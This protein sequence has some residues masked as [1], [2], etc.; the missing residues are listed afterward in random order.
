MCIRDRIYGQADNDSLQGWSGNDTVVGGSGADKIW[1]GDGRDYLVGSDLSGNTTQSTYVVDLGD[2][3]DG[4]A[5]NDTIF[6]GDGN[7][8][9]IGG[10]GDDWLGRISGS[11]MNLSD[12]YYTSFSNAE[13]GDDTMDGG[14]GNDNLQGGL[15]ADSLR[16]GDGTDW[17]RGHGDFY[18]SADGNDTLDGGFGDDYVYGD[19]GND[20]VSGGDGSDYVEGGWGNDTLVGGPGNDTIYGFTN[21]AMSAADYAYELTNNVDAV[22]YSSSTYSVLAN[23]G[24][25]AVTV[26]ATTL[27]A[28][29]AID[30]LYSTDAIYQIE[31]IIGGSS[32]D[33]LVGSS[34][35]N[36]L[37]GSAGDDT[38]WGGEG[39]DALYGD[40]PVS[41]SGGSDNDVFFLDL[42]D[43]L[44]DGGR[45]YDTLYTRYVNTDLTNVNNRVVLS[46]IEAVDLS[47]NASGVGNTLVLN[48]T[49]VLAMTDSNHKLHIEGEQGDSV[50][51]L[52][53]I[54]I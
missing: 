53:L 44:V 23:I 36:T 29:T 32:N 52:S 48:A 18:N 41:T 46:N 14:A 54:H 40:G 43:A 47:A 33:I 30:G 13:N 26:G 7:D 3:I 15:G 22:D 21:M 34:Y 27:L 5:G 35:A 19:Y 24:D 4:G 42:N 50:L 1:G 20:W 49:K 51:F 25:V 31:N 39:I 11:L 8:S 9:L 16:G 45:G 37:V 38:I 10:D 12:Y 6:G 28:H 17:I 2:T